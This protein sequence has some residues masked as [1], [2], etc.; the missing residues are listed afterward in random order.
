M[1]RRTTKV[2]KQQKGTLFFVAIP[3][4]HIEERNFSERDSVESSLINETAHSVSF[5]LIVSQTEWYKLTNA[6]CGQIYVAA[7]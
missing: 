5:S 3:S 4:Q 7:L 6:V 2:N 1:K